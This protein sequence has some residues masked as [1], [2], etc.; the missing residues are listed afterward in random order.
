MKPKP[1]GKITQTKR[2]VPAILP[3]EP[4]TKKALAAIEVYTYA[5]MEEKGLQMAY[6]MIRWVLEAERM[7]RTDLYAWLEQHGY[8]WCSKTGRRSKR[9]RVTKS[10][11]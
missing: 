4:L 3:R 6:F 5:K 1:N 9:D 11:K 10:E 8:H 7:R 2:A